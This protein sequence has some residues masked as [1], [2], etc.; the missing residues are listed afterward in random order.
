M[1]LRDALRTIEEHRAHIDPAKY[2]M[3]LEE[4]NRA[5]R[6]SD[7]SKAGEALE[8][9]DKGNL[10]FRAGRYGEAAEMYGKG[11]ELSGDAPSA[12]LLYSNRAA[13][14][15]KLGRTAEAISDCAKS[16]EIDS[17][18][19]KSYVRLAQLKRDTDKSEALSLLDKVLGMDPANAPALSLKKELDAEASGCDDLLKDPATMQ[20][21]MELL[22][23]PEMR[24]MAESFLANAT[25]EQKQKI[26]EDLK[27]ARHS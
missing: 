21:A 9:K 4:I 19:L 25:D 13:A 20:K 15:M 6:K 24:K 3:V 22:N 10:S 14:Y 18:Y 23:N 1:S 27:N 26:L 2:A 7:E 8:Y 11:I 17:G 12:S 16:I 5:I